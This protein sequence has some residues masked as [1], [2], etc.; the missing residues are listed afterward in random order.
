MEEMENGHQFFV[1]KP[2]G[3]RQ[4]ETPERGCEDSGKMDLK[5]LGSRIHLFQDSAVYGLL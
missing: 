2:E 3:K 5:Q 1:G 4:L